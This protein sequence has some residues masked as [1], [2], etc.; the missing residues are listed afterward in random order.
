[1]KNRF[2]AQTCLSALLLILCANGAMAQSA[3]EIVRRAAAHQELAIVVRLGEAGEDVQGFAPD[4]RLEEFVSPRSGLRFWHA[5][6]PVAGS[7]P[8]TLGWDG[9]RVIRLG[10]F[11]APELF[12][13]ADLLRRSPV[14]FN[15]PLQLAR[16][17]AILA[18]PNGGIES[19]FIT[20]PSTGEAEAVRSAWLACYPES[21]TDYVEK[22]GAGPTLVRLTLLTR[23]LDGAYRS[24]IPATYAFA[25]GKDRALLAWSREFGERFSSRSPGAVTGVR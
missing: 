7:A 5:R 17:L 25:F 4:V 10:G 20:E 1:M 23:D 15:D 14:L 21:A 3:E 11:E 9:S 8:Y 22:S 13:A 16:E 12:S 2:P 24:W 6:M 19:V 18:D